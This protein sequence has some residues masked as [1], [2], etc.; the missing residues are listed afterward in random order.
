MDAVKRH[1][2][3]DAVVSQLVEEAPAAELAH[4]I[5]D[6]DPTGVLTTLLMVVM[7]M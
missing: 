3:A 1:Q 7:T 6:I 5:D 4:G 2:A